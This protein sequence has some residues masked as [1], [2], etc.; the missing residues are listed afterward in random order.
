MT[1]LDNKRPKYNAAEDHVV[2]DTL[3]NISLSMDLS[4]V[5]LIE[6]LHQHESVK[7]DGVMLWRRSMKRGVPATVNIKDLLTC[8]KGRDIISQFYSYWM[9][10]DYFGLTL[11][12]K[13]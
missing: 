2:E 7:D 10:R 3:E 4:S 11:T 13:Q 9:L 6:E 8:E 5:N 12:C 1:Y